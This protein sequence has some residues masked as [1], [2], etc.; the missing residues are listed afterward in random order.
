MTTRESGYPGD[1]VNLNVRYSN[2]IGFTLNLYATTLSEVPWMDHGINQDTY[3]KYARKLSSLHF[4]LKPL[5]GKGK[6]PENVPYLSSDTVFQ[7]QMPQETGVYILQVVPDAGTTRTEDHFLISTRLKVML[8]DLG[9]GRTEV[10]TL[11][12]QDGQPIADTKVSFYSSYHE[13]N[14]TLV[15]EVVTDTDGKAIVPWQNGIRSYVPRKGKD[16]AMMPQNVYMNRPYSGVKDADWRQVTLLTD[17]SLYR[18]GQ[19]VY[20]KGVA[21]KQNNDSA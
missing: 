11:D 4:D 5:P 15:T 21:Y 9:D 7:F 3:K 6:L 20:V 18:P 8:L 16:T 14:R 2:L 13:Q 19:T 1:L 12:A 17:R 10:I